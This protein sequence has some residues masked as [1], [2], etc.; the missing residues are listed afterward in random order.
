M[1]KKLGILLFNGPD[2]QDV[3]TAIGLAES[4]LA[5]GV[6]VD[7]FM[8]HKAV[9]NSAV[10]ALEALADKGARITVCAHNADQLKAARSE[11]FHYGSQYDHANIVAD[12]DRYLA[13]V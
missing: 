9:L 8:M 13:F 4:A 1:A 10:P 11:K 6:E 7:I 5:R 12:S 2:S 3:H